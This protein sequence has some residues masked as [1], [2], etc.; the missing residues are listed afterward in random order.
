MVFPQAIQTTTA[1]IGKS[2][3]IGGRQIGKKVVGT[4]GGHRKVVNPRIIKAVLVVIKEVLVVENGGGKRHS[5][6]M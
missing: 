4:S 5:K 3:G 2:S 6:M 1:K